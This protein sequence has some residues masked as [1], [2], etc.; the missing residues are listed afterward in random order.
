L[1]STGEQQRLSFIRLFAFFTLPSNKEQLAKETLVFLD[2][3]TSAI[4]VQTEY[5]IYLQ[6]TQLHVWF[7]TISHRSSLKNLHA[8]YLEF[9]PEGYRYNSID[10]QHEDNKIEEQEETNEQFHA[11]IDHMPGIFEKKNTS[12]WKSIIDIFKFMHL[13]FQSD[14][15]KLKIQVSYVI[16]SHDYI[17]EGSV[18]HSAHG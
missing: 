2:E 6:L 12:Q 14:D 5:K 10:K 9:S 17:I 11:P 8:K 13:P 4:D 7:V 18:R 3:S 1:L 15:T 16:C